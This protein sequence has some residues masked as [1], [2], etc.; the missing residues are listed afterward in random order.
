MIYAI[1]LLGLIPAVFLPDILTEDDDAGDGPAESSAHPEQVVDLLDFAA[2]APLPPVV[3]DDAASGEAVTEDV[4]PPVIEDDTTPEEALLPVIEDDL[5][6]SDPPGDVEEALSPVIEDDV[7]Q[8]GPQPDPDQILQPVI[9]DDV[10][11]VAPDG[12]ALT[13]VIEDDAPPALP[14]RAEQDRS[15]GPEVELASEVWLDD[16]DLAAGSHAEIE[17]FEPGS[18]ILRISL[19]PEHGLTDPQVRVDLSENGT[20]S[21][22][23]IGDRLFAALLDAP[24]VTPDDVMLQVRPPA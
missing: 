3:E 19:D 6:P 21:E 9:E 15:Q 4:L 5:P 22:V 8:G 12:P 11:R 10:A 23:W 2:E 13:P 17:G 7:A 24:G 14:E 20:D 16:D 1:L 18:D